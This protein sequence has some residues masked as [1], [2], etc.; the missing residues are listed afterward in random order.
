MRYSNISTT[1]ILAVLSS[2]LASATV[3]LALRT[4]E[5]GSQS[6]VAYTNG[7]PDVCS[8]FTTIVDS[9]SDPCGISFD[10]DGNNGPF[11]FEGC[12]GNGLSLDQ[13]G[14]FNSN[15]EFQ[16]STISC[17]GGVTIQQNFACF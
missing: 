11:E 6:Q 7:T 3:F 9:N 4:G 2:P 1:V 8:G 16:S 14:S 13:D 10:V 5:D 12:G 15:C 17:P